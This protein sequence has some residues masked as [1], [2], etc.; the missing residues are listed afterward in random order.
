MKTNHSSNVAKLRFNSLTHSGFVT[1]I[2]GLSNQLK[3]TLG[4]N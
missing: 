4:F 2:D 1:E 3:Y